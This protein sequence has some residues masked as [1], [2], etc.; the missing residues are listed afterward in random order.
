MPS[1]VLEKVTAHLQLEAL[2]GGYEAAE[3]RSGELESVYQSVA[4]LLGAESHEIALTDNATRSWNQVFYGFPFQK[5]DRVLSCTSE[6]ASNAIAFFQ[7]RQRLGIEVVQVPDDGF[8]QI[9]LEQLEKELQ[10]GAALVCLCHVPTNGGL[11]QPAVAVGELCR[12]YGVPYLLDACQSAGQLPLCVKAIGCDFLSGT[13]RKY[14]R[15]PRGIGFLYVSQDWLSRLEPP[16]LDLHSAVWDR[17]QGYTVREDA[18]RFELWEADY[19]ARLGFGA[20]VDYYLN[21]DIEGCW[22]RLQQLGERLRAGLEG[23]SGVSVHDLGLLRGGIVTFTVD[24]LPASEVQG[25]LSTVDMRTSFCTVRSAR[26]DMERRGLLELVRASVH[27]YN[28]EEEVERFIEA[29]RT[30]I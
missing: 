28:T 16:T 8:G 15:G 4:R 2:R 3:L 19:A 7:Q 22:L 11:V 18:R 5:G 21:L 30:S 29:V 26:W 9:D 12:R 23:L 17:T 10:A 20:A 24:G 27:Y 6:Y 14:L 25:R 13:S 1:V